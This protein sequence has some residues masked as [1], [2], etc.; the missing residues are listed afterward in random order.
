MHGLIL[1]FWKVTCLE[2]IVNRRS[3]GLGE[4]YN[5]KPFLKVLFKD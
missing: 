1:I 3:E 4:K 2:N 5:V